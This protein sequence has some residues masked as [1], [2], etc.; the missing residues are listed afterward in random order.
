MITPMNWTTKQSIDS[1]DYRLPY[2]ELELPGL[3]VEVYPLIDGKYSMAAYSHYRSFY[4]ALQHDGTVEAAKAAAEAWLPHHFA[5]DF[6]ALAQALGGRVL[7]VTADEA[8]LAYD[9]WLCPKCNDGKSR[10]DWNT[11]SDPVN[12]LYTCGRHEFSPG[13]LEM[14]ERHFGPGRILLVHFPAGDE[15]AE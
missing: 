15:E 2:E 14:T 10:I 11:P 7:D 5:G 6:V 4:P 12:D 1:E 3:I 9:N 13:D 8:M